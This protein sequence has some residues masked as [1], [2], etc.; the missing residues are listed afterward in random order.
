ML[1]DISV[2]FAAT[3]EQLPDLMCR[4]DDEGSETQSLNGPKFERAVPVFLMPPPTRM[5]MFWQRRRP[6][7][8]KM[9]T[10]LEGVWQFGLG[11]VVVTSVSTSYSDA[12]VLH[13]KGNKGLASPRP[14]TKMAQTKPPTHGCSARCM[15]AYD[16]CM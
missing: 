12:W 7:R 15:H 13:E 3:E 4:C 10:A 6:N 8:R 16:A 14:T 1:G 11:A 2:E 5:H 9:S